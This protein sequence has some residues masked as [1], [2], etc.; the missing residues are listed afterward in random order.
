MMRTAVD[1]L[2]AGHGVRPMLVAYRGPVFCGCC[3]ARPHTDEESRDALGDLVAFGRGLDAT[4]VLLLVDSLARTFPT[5]AAARLYSE[6]QD[7]L[8]DPEAHN[9]LLLLIADRGEPVVH[10]IAL[11]YRVADDG[12]PTFAQEALEGPS[13]GGILAEV[14][15]G[16]LTPGGLAEAGPHHLATALADRGC[17]VVMPG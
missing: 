2:L 8:E 3:I 16:A 10:Q 7:P 1:A 15:M 4:T 13:P 12:A 11:D 5:V 9:S 14:V 6:T 17:R